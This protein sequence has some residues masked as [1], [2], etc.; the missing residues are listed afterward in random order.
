MPP[1]TTCKLWETLTDDEKAI[2]AAEATK[3]GYTDAAQW[4]V[5]KWCIP[6]TNKILVGYIHANLAHCHHMLEHVTPGTLLH[7][8]HDLEADVP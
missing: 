8:E 2:I 4:M 7:V 5:D 1:Q 3:D 6:G